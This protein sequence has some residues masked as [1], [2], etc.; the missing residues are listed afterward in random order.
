M[1]NDLN[2]KDFKNIYIV[3]GFTD[4]RLGING[5]S[6][7]IEHRYKMNI[8]IPKTLFLF[9]GQSGRLMKALLWEGD[10]FL[11]LVKRIE[12]GRFCWPRTSHDVTNLTPEQFKW[13]MQGFDINPRIKIIKPKH[14]A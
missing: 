11:M 4:M 1:L 9:C 5:L 14:C 12:S 10:G 8:F 2:P 6:S 13:L 3:C 7:I